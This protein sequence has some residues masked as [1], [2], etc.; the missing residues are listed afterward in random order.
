M[1]RLMKVLVGSMFAV[2][3]VQNIDTN[4]DGTHYSEVFR[5]AI[6][7]DDVPNGVLK[8]KLEVQISTSATNGATIAAAIRTQATANG[9]TIPANS[10]SEESLAQF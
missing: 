10:I 1:K 4:Y 2:A 6:F 9:I 8:L 7:G 3:Y 5:V